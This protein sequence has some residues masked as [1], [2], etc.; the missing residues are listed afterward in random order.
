M[1]V[2]W[3]VQDDVVGGYQAVVGDFELAVVDVAGV[4]VGDDEGWGVHDDDGGGD[5]GFEDDVEDDCVEVLDGGFYYF[6][7][8]GDEVVVEDDGLGDCHV[9]FDPE[10]GV[11]R[12]V[13]VGGDAAFVETGGEVLG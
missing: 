5:I 9:G 13:F 3:W 8:D 6:S 12:L 1:V 10:A 7:F 11:F 4:E 2:G